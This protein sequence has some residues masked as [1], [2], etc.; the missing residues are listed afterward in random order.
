MSYEPGRR[1]NFTVECILCCVDSI[2]FLV[3]VET[4]IFAI[5]TVYSLVRAEI[6]QS[7]TTLL[8]G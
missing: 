8:A 5:N 7:A 1:I 2:S 4:C 6:A 3:L